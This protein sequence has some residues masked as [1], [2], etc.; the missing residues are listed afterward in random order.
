MWSSLNLLSSLLF[1]LKQVLFPPFPLYLKQDEFE[2]LSTHCPNLNDTVSLIR[3]YWNFMVLKSIEYANYVKS[4]IK[5]K[6]LGISFSSNTM[7][8]MTE[9]D[10]KQCNKQHKKINKFKTLFSFVELTIQIILTTDE[11]INKASRKWANLI[12]EQVP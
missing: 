8:T 9:S 7:L 10:Q 2:H 5:K 4:E 12:N 3:K 1:N 6:K 11:P